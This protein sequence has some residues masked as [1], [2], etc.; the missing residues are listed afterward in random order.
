M[1]VQFGVVIVGSNTV[2]VGHFACL[3]VEMLCYQCDSGGESTDPC[4]VD[5]GRRQDD[6]NGAKFGSA[7]SESVSRPK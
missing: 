3:N 5:C 2:D 6:Q 7:L 1:E 4:Q